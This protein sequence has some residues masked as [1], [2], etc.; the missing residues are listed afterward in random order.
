MTFIANLQE[1]KACIDPDT[2]ITLTTRYSED[3]SEIEIR[4]GN[5]K[6]MSEEPNTFCS[7]ALS[8]FSDFFTHLEYVA[9]V[10]SGTNI[11][12]QNMAAWNNTTEADNAWDAA[13]AGFGA[14]T[15]FIGEVINGGLA[16]EDNVELII[17]ASTPPGFFVDVVELDSSLSFSYLGTDAWDPGEQI[18]IGAHP[19]VRNIGLDNS[20]KVFEEKPLSYFDE[21]D[22]GI[23]SNNKEV[24]N[25]IIFETFPNPFQD[26]ILVKYNLKEP[27]TVQFNIRDIQGKLIF[28][29]EVD[30]LSIG[31]HSQS[32]FVPSGVLEQGMYLLEIR[33]E[34][35]IGVQKILRM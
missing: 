20:S 9:F 13:Q 5:L 1:A 25:D 11:V 23:L 14:W 31:N 2:V 12:Y 24:R 26:N 34:Y 18:L 35:G 15:G 10:D 3:F 29:E 8:S 21:L 30:Q 32:I 17:R 6:L 7:C 27:S 16:P 19:G 28:T 22:N 4:L 33:T